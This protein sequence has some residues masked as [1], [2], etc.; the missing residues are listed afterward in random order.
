MTEIENIKRIEVKKHSRK[1][2]TEFHSIVVIK[3]NRK[4]TN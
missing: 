1:F 2:F 4:E 3:Y